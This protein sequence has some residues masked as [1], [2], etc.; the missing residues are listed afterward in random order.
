[1]APILGP[2]SRSEPGRLY[3]EEAVDEV[4]QCRR[5]L[6][7]EYLS[8]TEADIGLHSDRELTWPHQFDYCL[9]HTHIYPITQ[10]PPRC[11]FDNSDIV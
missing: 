2:F 3:P 1:M 4:P 6:S 8:E 5:R 10:R 7:I 11:P 9:H